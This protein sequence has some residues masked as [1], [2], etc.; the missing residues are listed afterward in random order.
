MS[1]HLV[2]ASWFTRA[3]SAVRAR[4]K[5][6]TLVS[7]VATGL[8]IAG[9]LSRYHHVDEQLDPERHWITVKAHMLAQCKPGD[10]EC[11]DNLIRFRRK[12]NAANFAIS[13]G[14]AGYFLPPE[15]TL[16]SSYTQDSDYTFTP[17]I[18]AES[19]TV[20]DAPVLEVRAT[21]QASFAKNAPDVLRSM[22][23]SNH[24]RN[25]VLDVM[26]GKAGKLSK[27]LRKEFD[28]R[29][30]WLSSG[31]SPSCR[32]LCED[33]YFTPHPNKPNLQYGVT[34]GDKMAEKGI[35][36]T[37]KDFTVA[38]QPSRDK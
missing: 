9:I 21:V 37:M 24:A 14:L 15:Y 26:H 28:Q 7:A 6:W 23:A 29:P 8:G 34:I 11:H 19:V 1:T 36:A 22:P 38:Y 30:R 10:T 12:I 17:D 16:D 13:T 31:R 18:I 3:A 32:E 20:D 4:P 33:R 27:C 2:T 5:L 35:T 25:V